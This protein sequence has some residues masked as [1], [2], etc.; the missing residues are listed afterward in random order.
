MTTSSQFLLQP[1]DHAQD[2]AL[3]LTR[4]HSRQWQHDDYFLDRSGR[5]AMP[6]TWSSDKKTFEAMATWSL[7]FYTKAL[8]MPKS[9]PSRRHSWQWQHDHNMYE[10]RLIVSTV[11]GQEDIQGYDTTRSLYL[12]KSR[13]I[14]PKTQSSDKTFKAMTT[15]SLL[16][17]K[18]LAWSCPRW[19]EDIQDNDNMI[20]IFRQKPPDHYF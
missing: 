16:L 6:E 1:L 20:T 15:S 9:L 3:V 5:L 18:S 17:Y 10:S 11:L 7:F 19:Q 13:M 12:D 4:R 8:I 14:M 2:A